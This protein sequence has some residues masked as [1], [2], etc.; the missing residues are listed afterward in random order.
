MRVSGGRGR[1]VQQRGG[2][3]GEAHR[4]D[5]TV[6]LALPVGHLA[7]VLDDDVGRLAGR[8]GAHDALHRQN[9]A[10]ERR[11]VAEGVQG[12]LA[13]LQLQR[14][15]GAPSLGNGLLRRGC[16]LQAKAVVDVG[17]RRHGRCAR[18]GRGGAA[19]RLGGNTGERRLQRASAGA[20]RG[21]AGRVSAQR[22]GRARRTR[23]SS[24]AGAR[25]AQGAR[26]ASSAHSP[27]SLYRV[28][29]RLRHAPGTRLGRAQRRRRRRRAQRVHLRGE[30]A[31]SEAEAKQCVSV[32]AN[33]AASPPS[34]QPP[35]GSAPHLSR[36][37]SA[38][39]EG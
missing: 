22:L 34:R 7:A 17:R 10:L 37:G 4:G 38:S 2:P 19:G 5:D 14:N 36:H 31:R 12:Q 28:G 1:S 29:S 20:R 32:P 18:Q 21:E 16:H 26:Q 3:A 27:S 30:G 24:D 6:G 15:L 39:G 33:E 23:R 11:L 25:A 8:L 13:L 9:L 35:R